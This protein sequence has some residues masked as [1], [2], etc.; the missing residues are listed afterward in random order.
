MTPQDALVAVMIAV[1]ASDERLRTE[2]LVT[3]ERIVNHLPAFAD[4]DQARLAEVASV[5]FDFYAEE[6]GLEPLFNLIRRV[7]PER[8]FETA[9]ALACDV[10]AS[11]GRRRRDGAA[12]ARGDPPRAQGRPPARR[13]HRARRPRPPPRPLTSARSGQ[14]PERWIEGRG[15]RPSPLERH[16]SER[17]WRRVGAGAPVLVCGLW[18]RPGRRCSV[19]DL[20][21][22]PAGEGRG[23][24]RVGHPG[25]VADPA[26]CVTRPADVRR[27]LPGSEDGIDLAR[28]SVARDRDRDLV[29]RRVGVES[30]EEVLGS[31]PLRARPSPTITSPHPDR[32][33]R[34]AMTAGSSPASSAGEP[35]VTPS[36][37]AP[38]IPRRRAIASRR[39]SLL[40]PQRRRRVVPLR[41][42]LRHH[43]VH[44]VDRH[45]EADPGARAR[46]AEDR[47]VHP[48]Q[49]PRAVEE[50]AARVA[51]VDRRVG[52]DQPA[53]R[54][55]PPRPAARGRAPRRSPWSASSRGRTGCRWRTRVCAHLAARRWCR[56]AAAAGRSAADVDPQHREV[57][58]AGSPP[59]AR[60]RSS[61]RRPAAPARRRRPRPRG[62]WS[63]HG[64]GRPRRSPTRSRCGCSWTLRVQGSITRRG[65]RDEDHAVARPAKQ[66][67]GRRLVPGQ[68]APR[69]H[70]LR[71][72]AL[73][74]PA[75]LASP[76][77]SATRRRP[78]PP[79]GSAPPAERESFRSASSAQASGFRPALPCW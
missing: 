63:R 33:R 59:P 7:L 39:G 37:T 74:E 19:R 31:R 75:R 36:T 40:H 67:D 9:Y 21:E 12:P 47:R 17:Q 52:L 25:Q 64:R 44:R 43:P 14:V 66:R 58:A 27:S 13:R 42:Q 38:S 6:D 23:A 3:I 65:G 15:P 51:R 49:P 26:R 70:H 11:D 56:A 76:A 32:A 16:W 68:V 46:R 79:R 30:R 62:R 69:G 22:A 61:A 45:R 1:S 55:R 78:R 71:L 41:D 72:R 50:R 5:V 18:R 57:V 54:P 28:A 2:E 4:Y 53:D 77:P 24:A 73:G 29:A 48:D 35:G 8:L 10:A 20:D 34:G 60:R